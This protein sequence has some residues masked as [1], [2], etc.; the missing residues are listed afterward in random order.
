MKFVAAFSIVSFLNNTKKDLNLKIKSLGNPTEKIDI[1]LTVKAGE[2]FR[3][4]NLSFGPQEVREIIPPIGFSI[5]TN[6]KEPCEMI[7]FEFDFAQDPLVG[8]QIDV[9]VGAQFPRLFYWSLF[10]NG[11]HLETFT[12]YENKRAKFAILYNPTELIVEEID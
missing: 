9:K 6:S 8:M 7:R 10:C 2:L 1:D 3:F 5:K 4:D 11:N 12:S